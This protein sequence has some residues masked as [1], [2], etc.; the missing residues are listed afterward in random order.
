MPRMRAIQA[1][2][3]LLEREG[4]TAVLGLP[5]A[6]TN[7]FYGALRDSRIRH[8]DVNLHAMLSRQLL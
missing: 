7:P 3:Q 4:V 5:G 6:A 1:A 8:K 2:V